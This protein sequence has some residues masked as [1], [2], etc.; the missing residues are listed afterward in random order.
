MTI[1]NIL[2]TGP[3]G[4]GKTTVLIKIKDLIKMQDQSIGGFYCPEIRSGK[5]RIGFSIIDLA[6]G[7]EGVLAS[8]EGDGPSLGQ[9]VINI[10]DL[11]NI[12]VN[13]IKHALEHADYIFIDEI[14]PMELFSSNFKIVVDQTLN[15][16]KPLIAVI[17]QKSKDKFIKTIKNRKDI[18]L[19]EINPSNRDHIPQLVMDILRQSKSSS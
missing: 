11:D 13:A 4:V 15:S 1:L 19:I 6:T 14:A 12:G 7:R 18:K 9:Y 10:E 5:R 8:L 16:D 2:I 3:P 17:H